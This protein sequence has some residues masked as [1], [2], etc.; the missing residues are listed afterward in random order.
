MDIHTTNLLTFL[1]LY[2]NRRLMFQT[3]FDSIALKKEAEPLD[4]ELLASEEKK[5]F[6]AL[7][8]ASVTTTER[9]FKDQYLET[10]AETF[11]KMNISQKKWLYKGAHLLKQTGE[12]AEH[13]ICS[14][15]NKVEPL[16]SHI[17]LYCA[18]F[19]RKFI[20]VF[21]R[22]QGQR[23][24]PMD[25]IEK[26]K[27]SFSHVCAWWNWNTYSEYEDDP[28]FQ[29]DHFQGKSTLAWRELT[30]NEASIEVYFS[31]GECNCLISL[32]DLILKLIEVFHFGTV[33]ERSLA[34]PILEKCESYRLKRK[35]RVHNLG[36]SGRILKKIVP[37]TPLDINLEPYIKHPIHFIAWSP[38]APRKTVKPSFEWSKFYNAILKLAIDS[39]G[40]AKFLDFDK[41]MLF[42]KKTDSV[43]PWLKA[44]E[45]HVQLL[46]E[47]S[48]D[49]MPKVFTIAK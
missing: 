2:L 11:N 3:G 30:D 47:M 4:R 32:S 5:P 36:K 34:R 22:A 40:C 15:L 13:V 46:Q 7:L 23:L 16:I 26:N 49:E 38:N 12:S 45:E 9:N 48:F 37:D 29:I 10:V 39:D 1:R 8:G 6:K 21:G 35:V 25:F 18:F 24:R 44:D 31:G 43:I 19:S 17:D 14:I 20:S 27:N 33:D 41:D 28:V 42:W